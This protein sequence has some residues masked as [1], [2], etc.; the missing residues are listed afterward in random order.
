[1][2]RIADALKRAQAE[3]ARRCDRGAGPDTDR[4][5]SAPEERVCAS[6][7][8]PNEKEADHLLNQMSFASLPQP[9]TKHTTPIEPEHL[10]PQVVVFHEPEGALAEKY[11]SLRTRL[12]TDNPTGSARIFGVTSSLAKEGKTLT[13]SNLGF[14]LTELRHLRVAMVDC[15]LRGRGLSR[16]FGL[17]D[18]P[19]VAEVLRGEQRLADVCLPLVR[20]N[21]YVIPAGD[22][23]DSGLSELLLQAPAA[24]MFK[25]FGKR[26]HYSLIDTPPVDTVSDIGMIAPMCHSIIMV[27]RMNRTPEPVL[28][29]CVKMLQANHVSI[30]GSILTGYDEQGMGYSEAHDYYESGVV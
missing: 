18:K 27:I 9:V 13:V 20:E 16:L 3:R 28:H 6:A 21:L 30:A 2:G 17:E 22:P 15:D 8:A 1:M 29:R 11:R 24:A 23:G 4:S 5:G 7:P 12:L 10:D 14:A 19:G 26:F 25:E